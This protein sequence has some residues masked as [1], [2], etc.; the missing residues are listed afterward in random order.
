MSTLSTPEQGSDESLFVPCPRCGSSAHRNVMKGSDYLHRLGDGFSVAACSSCE[1]WFLN[2]VPAQ[3]A[4]YYPTDY[5]PHTERTVHEVPP[6]V[7]AYLAR[8]LDYRHLDVEAPVS[9]IYRAALDRLRVRWKVCCDLVPRF[10][11]GGSV[12]EIGAASGQRL[13]TLRE[14]GWRNLHGI[15]LMPSAAERARALGLDVVCGRVEDT[16]DQYKDCTFDVVVS[17][18][19][20]EHLTNPFAV[21]NRVADKLK[22]GGQFLFST[23]TR[24]SLDARMFG[25]Y[26]GGFDFP[27]HT[28]FFRDVDIKSMVEDKFEIIE[29]AHHAAPQDFF[30]SAAWRADEGRWIDKMILA[31]KNPLL[32]YRLGM[33]LAWARLTCRVSYRCQKKGA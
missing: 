8:E 21:V 19:V 2:P 29:T 33:A 5:R 16:L 28:V 23:I 13:A 11:E 27:R 12:L 20:I 1:L 6:R 30:R 31:I 17:S 10:V 14:L 7:R 32:T 4:D 25:K 15:E 24:D 26:W 3:L 9:P 18:M 22:P